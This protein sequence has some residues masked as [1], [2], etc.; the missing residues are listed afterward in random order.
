MVTDGTSGD[1]GP[2]GYLPPRAAKRARKIVLRR[3]MGLQWPI[4]AVV[5][6][7]LILAVII[8][9]VW[10][11]QQPP[12]APY[13][14]AGPLSA[15][16]ASADGRLMVE[17]T[18][19]LILRGGGVL[20]AFVEVPA[21]ARYCPESRRIESI[22]GQVWTTQGRLIAG[23]GP[24][25]DQ[26]KV[27]AHDDTLYIDLSDRTPGLPPLVDDQVSDQQPACG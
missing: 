7:A 11:A 19:V 5:A 6:G 16:D 2:G 25:L 12:R 15:I 4:A 26:V 17:G 21:D 9:L 20:Q 23:E 13:V 22:D 1:F 27:L 14:P 10:S 3:Q 24:S 8:P 18:D